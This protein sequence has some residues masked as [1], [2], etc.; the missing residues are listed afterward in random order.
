[1]SIECRYIQCP[2]SSGAQCIYTTIGLIYSNYAI[3]TKYL[4]MHTPHL[5]IVRSYALQPRFY[6]DS[7]QFVVAQF[8]AFS[9]PSPC[10]RGDKGG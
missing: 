9:L 8:I 4:R 1:M 6:R 7:K 3:M 10:L 5:Y 2:R